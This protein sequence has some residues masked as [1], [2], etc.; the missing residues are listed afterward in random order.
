MLHL[1]QADLVEGLEEELEEVLSHHQGPLQELQQLEQRQDQLQAAARQLSTTTTIEEVVTD[2]VDL[3]L[4][5]DHQWVLVS[6]HLE[7]SALVT[8]ASVSDTTQLFL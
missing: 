6:P 5:L 3:Q 1:L 7:D 8:E 4:S 2:T